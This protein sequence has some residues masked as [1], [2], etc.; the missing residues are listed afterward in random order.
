MSWWSWFWRRGKKAAIAGATGETAT[1]EE[2]IDPAAAP[3]V[4]RARLAT[5]DRERRQRRERREVASETV[6][7]ETVS[8]EAVPPP[9]ERSLDELEAELFWRTTHRRVEVQVVS[10]PRDPRRGA[11]ADLP[12]EAV[13]PEQGP[14]GDAEPVPEASAEAADREPPT[15]VELRDVEK[16]FNA[17]TRRAYTALKDLSFRVEDRPGSGEFIAIVGPSGCGKSTILNLI[18]GFSDVH[19]PTRGKVLVHGQPVHGPGRD[20]GMIFQKYSSFPQR[21]VLRNVTFGLEINRKELGMPWSEMADRAEE[22]IHRVGLAGHE[23]KYPHQLSGGQQQRVAI[24]RSL[25]L[26]PRILLMDE[27]FSALD[28]PTRYEMQRLIVELWHDVQATVF[29]VTHS[30]AE[31][32]YLGDRVW[33]MTPAPGRVGASFENVFP[34]RRDSDPLLVQE[35]GSFKETV[36]EVARVFTEI[37]ESRHEGSDNGSNKGSDHGSKPDH[38]P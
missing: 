33:I 17:G 32:V 6:S 36:M 7:L 21:T 13:P 2:P 9:E 10:G 3:E 34:P 28:E 37:S 30:I 20:R 31:A 25:V 4:Q 35:S 15:I 22:M 24:A 38:T 8:R 14:P 18:Q 1:P 5:E 27:P 11:P 26:K 16:T 23:R 19:P 12:P 29:L